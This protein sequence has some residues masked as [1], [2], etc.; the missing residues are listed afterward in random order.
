[1]AARRQ[2]SDVGVSKHSCY[3][4][5]R[6]FSGFLSSLQPAVK[7]ACLRFHRPRR[8]W[9]RWLWKKKG[10]RSILRSIVR[11]KLHVGDNHIRIHIHIHSTVRSRVTVIIAKLLYPL[12]ACSFS[13]TRA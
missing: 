2:S 7:L 3:P 10:E 13:M 1:M 12:D 11:H 4:L 6:W 9:Q 5:L 8:W